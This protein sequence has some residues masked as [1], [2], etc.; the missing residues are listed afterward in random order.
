MAIS[1]E[2]VQ[3][4]LEDQYK[5]EMQGQQQAESGA[6]MQ[7]SPSGN[8]VTYKE[9]VTE[10]LQESPMPVTVKEIYRFIK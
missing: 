10:A 2:D 3:A 8:T 1:F 4:W 6:T 7:Q 9:A 5:T